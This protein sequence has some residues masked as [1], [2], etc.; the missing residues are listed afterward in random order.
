MVGTVDRP[1]WPIVSALGSMAI[2]PMWL[3]LAAVVRRFA[4][5]DRHAPRSPDG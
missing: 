3:V 5:A 4:F 2:L 1:W